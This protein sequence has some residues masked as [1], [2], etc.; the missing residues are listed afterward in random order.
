MRRNLTHMDD[1]GRPAM[2]D[3]GGKD[4]TQRTAEAGCLVEVGSEAAR[5]MRK[6]GMKKGSPLPVAELAGI[7][8]A[9]RTPDLIPLCHPLALDHVAVRCDLVGESVEIRASVA[10]R[11]RTGVEM[12]AMT[13]AAVAAL[14][15]YD[16]CKSV[17]RGIV[18]KEL[19]LLKKSG[20]KSGTYTAG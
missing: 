16:M 19:R 6:G 3:V 10:C 18:I 1:E 8:G 11:G 12:E 9:K 15:V 4:E 20:G 7:M 2:V 5:L 14:T 17:S 13:A